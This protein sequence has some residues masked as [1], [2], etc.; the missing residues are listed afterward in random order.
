MTTPLTKP[1]S[2]PL[3]KPRTLHEAITL[4]EAHHL[5]RV[6]S[7]T[8]TWYKQRLE[9][10]VDYVGNLNLEQIES[11]QIEVWYSSLFDEQELHAN[12]PHRDNP[13]KKFSTQTIHGH[14]RAVK[15]FFRWLRKMKL[16]PENPAQDLTLPRLTRQP[17]AGI[18]EDSLRR[19]LTFLERPDLAKDNGARDK[20]ILLFMAATGVRVGGV[21]SLKRENI[22]LDK[23]QALVTEKGDKSRFVFFTPEVSAAIRTYHQQVPR[24]EYVFLSEWRGEYKPISHEGIRLMIARRCKHADVPHHSPHD[25]RR[26]FASKA[27]NAGCDLYWLKNILGHE[28]ITTT[29]IY[30]TQNPQS[31]QRKYD[32]LFPPSRP[33]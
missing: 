7:T 16:I 20:A 31:L 11:W 9:R 15:T 32:D 30:L 18:A 5:R 2:S 23:R 13:K 6:A 25:F 8:A 12:N 29:E 1:P 22:D 24:H 33:T 26:Y 19:I 27:A 14:G 28:S 4:F 21:A 3:T 10:F 17:K